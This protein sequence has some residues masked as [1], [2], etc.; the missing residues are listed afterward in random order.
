[1]IKKYWKPVVVGF[2]LFLSLCCV[3]F[4]LVSNKPST[5][6]N[7]APTNIPKST[8]MP[9]K[10]IDNTPIPLDVKT[11]NVKFLGWLNDFQSVN[12]VVMLIVSNKPVSKTDIQRAGI[13]LGKLRLDLHTTIPPKEYSVAHQQFTDAIDLYQAALQDFGNNKLQDGLAKLK[14]AEY[15]FSTLLHVLPTPSP[16]N[17][18]VVF[19]PTQLPTITETS[20]EI[21]TATNIPVPTNTHIVPTVKRV[22]PKNTP[23]VV[24]VPPTATQL[25]ANIIICNDGYVWPGTTRQGA[26]HGHKGIRK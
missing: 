11:Y 19:T 21:N 26:C 14:Q 9:T 20:T 16:V 4:A 13:T 15:L 22:V 8:V 3:L 18:Q 1:M 12:D 7:T 25:P 23:V 24:P 10:V 6:N 17:T 2:V 5:Q